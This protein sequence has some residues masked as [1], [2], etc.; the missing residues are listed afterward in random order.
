MTSK[1]ATWQIWT[2][3]GGTFTDCLARDPSGKLHRAK[4]LSSG[5]LRGVV[6]GQPSSKV[7]RVRESW[8]APDG[9]AEGFVLHMMSQAQSDAVTVLRHRRLPTQEDGATS[10]LELDR[11]VPVAAGQT[12]EVHSGQEA[13]LLAARLVTQTSA[14]AALPPL[15]FRL[16]TTRGT[17]ALLTRTGTPPAFFVTAGF[18]DCLHIGT[19]QRPDLFALDIQKPAP[20][21]GPVV[22]VR[23]R[24]NADGTVLCPLDVEQL[25]NE[26][27][28]LVAKGVTTAAIAFLHS[29]TNPE[30]ERQ[31]AV[32]LQEAGFTHVSVSSELAPF[33]RHLFRAQTAVTNAYLTP[34]L[35]RYLGNVEDGLPADSSLHV[36]TSAGGLVRAASFAP[37]DGL[38]SGPA[39]GVVGAQI[40]GARAGFDRV[41]AFDMG[42]TSTDVARVD[43]AGAFD[44]VSEHTVGDAHLLAPALAVHTVAAGG[45]SICA[46]TAN[47]LQVGPQSAGASPGP[48]CYDTG[49]PLTITDVNLLLGRLLPERFGLPLVP[50]RASEAADTLAQA[51]SDASH[52]PTNRDDLLEGLLALA[53]ERMADAIRRVSVQKGYDPAEYALLSFGGAGGQHACAVA[54]RLN[55]HTVVVPLDASLLS[56]W[57]I[58]HA[59]LERFARRQVLLPL[60]MANLGS[61][62]Q[63]LE[64]AARAAVI[65]EGVIPERVQ[66]DR[67][68]VALRLAGQDSTLE[69][70]V[71]NDTN[72]ST[73]A[74]R[75]AERYQSVYGQL[76]PPGRAIE[77]ESAT[78][79][80]RAAAEADTNAALPFPS[81]ARTP[82]ATTRARFG[83]VWRDVPVYERDA[84]SPVPVSGP[85]LVVEAHSTVVVAPGWSCRAHAPSGALVLEQTGSTDVVHALSTGAVADELFAAR[86][87]SVADEMGEQ[88]RRT[89]FSVN[90]KERLDFSCA[91]LNP[92]GMLVAS[93]AHIP[94]HLG[95]LGACVRGVCASLPPLIPGD[96]LITNHPAF[97]GSHLPDVTIITPVFE[98]EGAARLLGFVASRAHHAEIGG[99]RPGSMPP[100][101]T[102][103]AEE[104]VVLPPLY[105]VRAGQSRLDAVCRLFAN[106]PHPSRAI[107]ENRADLLAQMAANRRGEQAL[108]LLAARYGAETVWAQMSRLSD[109]AEARMRA[110][111]AALP[112]GEY[113]ATDTLDDGSPLCVRISLTPNGADIDFAGTSP[114]HPGNLNAPPAVVQSAVLYVLRLLAREDLP[115]NEGLL[116]PVTLHLP[117]RTL[118]NPA[119]DTSD[120]ARCPA[121]VGG[122]TEVSQRI[123][124]LLLRAFGLAAGSQGTM[125]NL[126]FGNDNPENGAVFGYYE[127]VCGGAGA[128]SNA[129]GASAVH[130]HMTN[131]RITDAE[132]L[133]RR[134]PVHVERFAIRRGSGGA[135]KHR[136]GDSIV[137]EITFL[138]P[139]ALSVLTQHRTSG[140][141]GMAGGENGQPGHQRLLRADGTVLELR[142]VDGCNVLPE[143]RLI[144][145]T[146]GGGGYGYDLV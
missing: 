131:T 25:R 64:N 28:R 82:T 2:D 41:I 143:D 129:S 114:T 50:G 92:E 126:L 75:F 128:T 87:A 137:R 130:T 53:D 101:A 12:F 118:V 14:K 49:G 88:L 103:L 102:T 56:A 133:E 57:G 24:L 63:E 111:L 21:H 89:A 97:G 33:V 26:A 7:L 61:V 65:S 72:A 136:G 84:L 23:E 76:P 73:L 74:A 52:T 31:T 36:M 3:T 42:G 39:G 10:V 142:S 15:Q 125:N 8:N 83:G 107:A 86:F 127:T 121:V 123:V 6:I 98:N 37:K 79:R 99:T 46:W 11:M 93:A 122:N 17:N 108:Q 30:H 18:G 95:A 9:F 96:V 19:Q 78:V 100:G 110:V 13:P 68:T 35:S 1:S 90:V 43:G 59:A 71:A 85:A 34:V 20:L 112:P 94:V 81:S 104:G 116:H 132:I 117:Q 120:P 67:R 62:L 47:G 109:R 32:T 29:Y 113:Q 138:A 66:A 48:A 4:V 139:M 55:I 106:A 80:A 141:Y 58:G 77:V 69:I 124:N 27:T 146:P 119:F 38:L 51:M 5:R 144:L 145:E 44:Y 70:E 134:Y 115:L 16:A 22:E 40:A 135:G 91:L 140:P 45:G 60:E 105:L 54:A